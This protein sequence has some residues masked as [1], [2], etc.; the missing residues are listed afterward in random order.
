M[1]RVK[2]LKFL[3]ADSTMK[4]DL[5]QHLFFRQQIIPAAFLPPEN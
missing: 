3:A 4:F 2:T 1:K 5:F